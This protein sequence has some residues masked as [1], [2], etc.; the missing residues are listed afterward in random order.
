MPLSIFSSTNLA[1]KR[2][3]LHSFKLL[4]L[5]N[6]K[7]A[8]KSSH[9]NHCIHLILVIHF[10]I[11]D[12]FLTKWKEENADTLFSVNIFASFGINIKY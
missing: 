8:L 10:Q 11:D 1:L 2:Y 7:V 4:A 6:H 3:F 9:S 12:I 5:S